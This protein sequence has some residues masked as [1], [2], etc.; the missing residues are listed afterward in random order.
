MHNQLTDHKKQHICV[1]VRSI[2]FTF[3]HAYVMLI[4]LMF[5]AIYA[6][7]TKVKIMELV[8]ILYVKKRE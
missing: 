8:Y 7:E 1:A 3:S 6:F 2:F 5:A 4:C